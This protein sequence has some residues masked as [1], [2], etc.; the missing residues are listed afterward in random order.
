MLHS[1]LILG[2]NHFIHNWEVA[3]E[4]ERLALVVVEEDEGKVCRQLDSNEFYILSDYSV[5]DWTLIS[6][7]G[8]SPSGTVGVPQVIVDE[9]DYPIALEEANHHFLHPES[10]AN[11]RGISIPDNSTVAFPLGTCLTFVNK[12]VETFDVFYEVDDTLI[13]ADYGP[14][15]GIELGQHGIATAMKITTT[16]WIISG[17][18]FNIVDLA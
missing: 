8:S 1:R 12:T 11:Q 6:T 5:P 18:G 3:N 16:S 9:D 2:E 15:E 14:V 10:D 13:V 7:S 17:V 4:T